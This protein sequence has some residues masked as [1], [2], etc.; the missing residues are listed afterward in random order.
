MLS[1]ISILPLGSSFDETLPC[2]LETDVLLLCGLTEEDGFSLEES[3]TSEL[4]T[5]S[6]LEG[7]VS[8]EDITEEVSSTVTSFSSQAVKDNIKTTVNAIAIIL[9]NFSMIFINP[10]DQLIID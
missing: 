10:L 6:E 4:E 7:A 2:G 8:L 9:L 1:S 5:V 3:A